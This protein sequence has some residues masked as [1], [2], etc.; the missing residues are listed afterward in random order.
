MSS[1]A[2]VAAALTAAPSGGTV[3]LGAGSY[4]YNAS[5]TK[6]TMTTA[7]AAPGVARTAVTFAY[8][9]TNSS[10]NIRLDNVTVAGGTIQGATRHLRLTRIRFTTGVCVLATGTGM[11]TVIDQSTFNGLGESCNEGRLSIR[12]SST[13]ANGFTVSNSEFTGGDSD[14]IQLVN[15][16]NGTTIGPGNTFHDINQ[17]SVHCDAIQPYGALNTLVTGNHFKNLDGVVANFD[18]NGSPLHMIG[19][20]IDQ[21]SASQQTAIAVTGARGDRFEH[22]TMSATTELQIYGGNP[23][24]C[25]NTGMTI[26]DN[27]LQGGCT[28]T[29]GSGNTIATNLIRSGTGCASAS[30]TVGQ[31]TYTGGSVPA[32]WSAWRL[33][34]GSLGHLA[35]SDGLD[36]G[37]TSFGSG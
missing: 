27:I 36:M 9:N 19:N 6:T 25:T 10:N 7:T 8:I 14:A 22:N 32:A 35:A 13:G 11:D 21:G 31:P 18:C 26:R 34:S 1:G 3:C 23:G 24:T 15:N 4:T 37:A 2:S 12:G 17:C 30:N 20:V 16:A 33:T 29:N 28:I 5:V